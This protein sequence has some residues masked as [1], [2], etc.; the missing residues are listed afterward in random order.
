M[1]HRV[2]V[3]LLIMVPAVSY[4]QEPPVPTCPQEILNSGGICLTKK[5]KEELRVAIEELDNIHQSKAEIEFSRPIVI[6]RDWEDRV[7]INGGEKKP[8]PMKLRIGEHVDRDLEAQ[9]PVTVFYR[10][11]PPDP[12]LRL[13]I[14]AQFGILVPEAIRS[15]RNADDEDDETGLEEF[16]D[17]AF[18]L[19]F[20]HYESLNLSIQVGARALGGGVGVDLTK[21][22]GLHVAPVV[23]YDGWNP[24]LWLGPYFSFN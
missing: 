4:A 3:F 24:S 15:I 20:F 16:W 11:E 12:W 9:L 19:D 8:I 23:A 6:V 17:F 7:Y 5:Q 14:R 18:A 21:N 2:T 22:F 13:R 10:D 1:K